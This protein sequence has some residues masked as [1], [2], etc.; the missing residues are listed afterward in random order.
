MYLRRQ[1]YVLWVR[2]TLLILNNVNAL[3]HVCFVTTER[4]VLY[5]L[6]MLLQTVHSQD[7]ITYIA[8]N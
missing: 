7:T 3:L 2:K 1:C 8:R 4:A 5:L 6:R